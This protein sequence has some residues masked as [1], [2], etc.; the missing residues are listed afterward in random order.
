MSLAADTILSVAARLNT[1]NSSQHGRIRPRDLPLLATSKDASNTDDEL[2]QLAWKEE[3][4]LT[5]VSELFVKDVAMITQDS[6]RIPT[7]RNSS[8]QDAVIDKILSDELEKLTVDE[9][10]QIAYEVHGLLH[11]SHGDPMDIDLRLVELEQEIRKIRNRRDYE[12]AK[13]LNEA[14]VTD[15]SFRL[16]F[17]R[18]D[19]FN[20][21]VAAQRIVK[22]FE[23]KREIFGE[24]CLA[25]PIRMS[26]LNEDELL[27]LNSG[28]FHLL[29]SRDVAGRLVLVFDP[30]RRPD[31]HITNVVSG[32]RR[33][34]R[35]I[36]VH[37]LFFH[38]CSP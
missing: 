5:R 19:D 36:Q 38:I 4:D 27:V 34:R 30:G 15:R 7:A 1:A 28:F 18:C 16:K 33:R 32:C 24:K 22:H 14:F 3:C 12:K 11:N 13:Y 26:D 17:L 35:E 37:A 25:R 31:I 8:E 9:R 21:Q 23:I 29:S 2:V 20:V 6:T 10:E